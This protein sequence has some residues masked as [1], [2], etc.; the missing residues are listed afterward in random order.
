MEYTAGY[1]NKQDV[2]VRIID[3]PVPLS[4]EISS[5]VSGLYGRALNLAA[6]EELSRLKVTKGLVYIED[7]Q[8][9]DF[10][11]RARVRSAVIA[12]REAGSDI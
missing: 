10:V 5:S 1:L 8:A 6:E 11:L 12:L 3:E 9:L 7:N 2:L 4:V